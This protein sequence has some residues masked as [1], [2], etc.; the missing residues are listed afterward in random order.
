MFKD[1]NKNYVSSFKSYFEALLELNIGAN[2]GGVEVGISF[3]SN[4]V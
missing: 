3:C 2:H 4:Y 1:G